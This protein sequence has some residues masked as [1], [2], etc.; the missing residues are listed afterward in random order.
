MEL[1][2]KTL[3]QIREIGGDELLGR[4]A[5]LYLEHTPMRLAEIRRGLAAGDWPRA[6]RAIHS[7]RSSSLTLGATELGQSAAAMETVAKQQNREQ[8]E[9]WLPGLEKQA[10]AALQALEKLASQPGQTRDR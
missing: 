4:L 1:D 3:V 2:V 6:E 9:S 5:R 10:Q 8:L 7:L